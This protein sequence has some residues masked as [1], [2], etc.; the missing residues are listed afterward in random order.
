MCANPFQNAV[1]YLRSEVRTAADIEK[2]CLRQ[3][4]L[5]KLF[6]GIFIGMMAIES[7]GKLIIFAADIVDWH[8]GKLNLIVQWETCLVI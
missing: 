7:V 4:K 6:T 3:L 5:N 1:M 8:Y 2:L